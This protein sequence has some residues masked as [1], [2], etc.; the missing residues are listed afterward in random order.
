[1]QHV[2]IYI[3]IYI[4]ILLSEIANVCSCDLVAGSRSVVRFEKRDRAA[5]TKRSHDAYHQTKILSIGMTTCIAA[6]SYC[7][8]TA[9][10]NKIKYVFI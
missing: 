3:Y 10:I 4:Y 6:Y 9:G 7:T 1:M 8:R 2:Y 5:G